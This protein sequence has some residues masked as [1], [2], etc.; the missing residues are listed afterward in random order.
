MGCA[1]GHGA[2]HDSRAQALADSRATDA[3]LRGAG[4]ATDAD[5]SGRV[6]AAVPAA[7]PTFDERVAM[8]VQPLL[9]GDW[10]MGT[11]VALLAGGRYR[12]YGFGATHEGGPPPD[13]HTLFEIGSIT[14]TF[15]GLLLAELVNEG[16][17]RLE[18]PVAELLPSGVRVPDFQGRQITLVDLAT[19]TSGLPRLPAN[20]LP[21]PVQPED[22]LDPYARYDE[23]DLFEFL[24]SY[25]LTVEPGTVEEYSNLG[26][27]LLGYALSRADGTSYR[28]AIER[29]ITQPLGMFDTTIS[30]TDAQSERFA[31]GHDADLEARPLWNFSEPTAGAGALRSTVP[32]LVSYLF[33]QRG[34]RGLAAP[35]AGLAEDAGGAS[36]ARS[37]ELSHQVFRATAGSIQQGLGWAVVPARELVLH[38]GATGGFNSIVLYDKLYDLGVVVLSNTASYSSFT[39]A[40]GF[41]L[42]TLLYGGEPSPIVLPASLRL[43]DVELE[44]FVGRYVFDDGVL[45]IA[46]S[47]RRM[48]AAFDAGP[49]LRIFPSAHDVLSLRDPQNGGEPQVLFRFGPEDGQPFDYV[50]IEQGEVVQL[51]RR[52]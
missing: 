30:L 17:V 6:D 9:D 10:I 36:L 22:L 23:A 12:A 43:N 15:T 32:D 27:G 14:K 28:G 19:H 45:E 44:R 47:G 39:D 4:P 49:A 38:N 20:L 24:S 3:G 11:E 8:L 33:A 40:L 16:R 13:E 18:Q 50:S 52:R 35:D 7:D 31:T 5:V 37:V 29:H 46:H 42:L 25:E 41:E 48:T 26:F 1:P 34:I 51:A 21:E 2:T